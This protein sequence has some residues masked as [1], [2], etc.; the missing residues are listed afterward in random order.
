MKL[1]NGNLVTTVVQFAKDMLGVELEEK[2][3]SNAIK[4]LKFAENIR[5]ADALKNDNI[6]MFS[7]ILSGTGVSLA[8][9]AEEEPVS[10]DGY[11][12]ANTRIPAQ[13]TVAAQG[14]QAAVANRRA[15][16][17]AQDAA[18]DQT[19]GQRQVAG[20]NKP[21]PGNTGGPQG[22]RQMPT[23][24]DDIQMGQN[25]QVANQAANQAAANAQE[26][27]RLKQLAMGRR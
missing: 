26:I 10:E 6:E 4:Q 19:G 14:S 2:A 7:E 3:V 24:P 22:H 5:L 18:R 9:A 16:N 20:G 1:I 8:P 27:E 21:A 25:A 23:D 12:S 15:N 11:G 17:A 13:S